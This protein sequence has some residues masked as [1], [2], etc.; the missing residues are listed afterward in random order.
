MREIF[1]DEQKKAA[2]QVVE[3]ATEGFIMSRTEYEKTNPSIWDADEEIVFN[4]D[5][6]LPEQTREQ[7]KAERK[8]TQEFKKQERR[9]IR[10]SKHPERTAD[11]IIDKGIR[12]EKRAVKRD[13]GELDRMEIQD[14]FAELEHSIKDKF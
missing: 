2:R 3:E 4:V 8:E 7:K 1:S 10:D 12:A 11:R 13:I 6:D 5:I 9:E 14:K